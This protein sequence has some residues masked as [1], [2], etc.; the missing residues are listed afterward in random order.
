MDRH[1]RR[2]LCHAA[3]LGA[4]IPG[5]RVPAGSM[6]NSVFTCVAKI[7]RHIR[8][9]RDSRSLPSCGNSRRRMYRRPRGEAACPRSHWPAKGSLHAFA[10]GRPDGTV[11]S[12]RRGPPRGG[13]AVDGR[14]DSGHHPMSP[15]GADVVRPASHAGAPP[16]TPPTRRDLAVPAPAASATGSPC[17]PDSDGC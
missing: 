15:R 6:A 4:W 1:P 7:N 17:L 9:V 12:P 8:A 11:G 5:P 16:A 14:L 3:V 2:D 10:R 13:L